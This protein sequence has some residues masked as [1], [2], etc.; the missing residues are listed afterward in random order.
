MLL[1]LER[2]AESIPGQERGFS[3]SSGTPYQYSLDEGAVI[4]NFGYVWQLKTRGPGK[5]GLEM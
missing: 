5:N 2:G 4:S 1:S 3:H